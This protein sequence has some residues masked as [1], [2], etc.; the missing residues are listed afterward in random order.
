MIDFGRVL[1]STLTTRA[2][3]MVTLR[4]WTYVYGSSFT[5]GNSRYKTEYVRRQKAKI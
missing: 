3:K 1:T 5:S 4:G 2:D